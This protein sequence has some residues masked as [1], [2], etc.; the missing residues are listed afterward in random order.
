MTSFAALLAKRQIEA[1]VAIIRQTERGDP[2]PTVSRISDE[3]RANKG[4]VAY[5]LNGLIGRDF[6][7]RTK[8]GNRVFWYITADG[9]S[10][11]RDV[12]GIR[13]MYALHAI[14]GLLPVLDR[15]C[16]EGLWMNGAPCGNCGR[17][18]SRI[19]TGRKA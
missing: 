19:F 10:V 7:C 11:L 6:V 3:I 2:I 17:Y 1:L 9:A 4:S 5:H 12:I 16:E 15:A 14:E 18:H 13:P 8:R